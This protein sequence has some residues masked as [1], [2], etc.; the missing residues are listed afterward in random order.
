[1]TEADVFH[2]MDVER[3]VVRTSLMR[4]TIHLVSA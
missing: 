1:M 3:S 2:A 4:A